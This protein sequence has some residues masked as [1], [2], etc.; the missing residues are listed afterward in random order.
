MVTCDTHT[1]TP[2]LSFYTPFNLRCV[3]GDVYMYS[4]IPEKHSAISTYV[5]A[6]TRMTRPPST[7]PTL[8][9]YMESTL[10][11]Y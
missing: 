5:P 10:A 7:H 2:V 8:S 9:Q 1:H 4:E 6:Q 11:L 3:H